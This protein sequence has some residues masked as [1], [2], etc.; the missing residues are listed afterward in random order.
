MKRLF[1]RLVFSFAIVLTLAAG[2]AALA[3]SKLNSDP[4]RLSEPDR[5]ETIR[6]GK[7]EVVFHYTRNPDDLELHVMV[8]NNHDLDD[9]LQTRI[10]LRDGQ[11][12]TLVVRDDDMD[13]DAP[14]DRMTFVRSRD[15]IVAD[16]SVAKPGARL[17]SLLWPFG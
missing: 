8:V 1:V 10:R 17:A 13:E 6:I 3:I 2:S 7:T 9:V 15:A 16:M 4:V 14:G 11:I 5:G 12:Y